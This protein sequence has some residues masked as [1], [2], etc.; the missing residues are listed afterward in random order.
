MKGYKATELDM[1]CKGYQFEMNKEFIH[2]GEIMLCISGFHF[3]KE[4]KNVF[5]HYTLDPFVRV[6]EV[7]IPDDAKVID[8]DNK[9]VTNKI[10]FIKELPLEEYSEL[11]NGKI[12]VKKLK[13]SYNYLVYN[14]DDECHS[15]FYNNSGLYHNENGPAIISSYPYYNLIQ[16]SYYENGNYI[17]SETIK[18]I[19]E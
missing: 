19:I 15:I 7:E 6:F 16:K 3:C 12:V 17:R 13:D 4:F 1:T 11:T 18:E 9:S 10:K 8:W 2:E 14:N 5:E